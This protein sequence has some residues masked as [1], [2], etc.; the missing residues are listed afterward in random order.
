[1]KAGLLAG[2]VGFIP[3]PYATYSMDDFALSGSN[4]TTWNDSSAGNHDLQNAQSPV[5][6]ATGINGNPTADFQDADRLS[7]AVF[8]PPNPAAGITIVLGIR[9]DVLAVDDIINISRSGNAATDYQSGIC[10]QNRGSGALGVWIGDGAGGASPAVS[11]MHGYTTANSVVTTATN[12]IVTVE[13]R[14][15]GGPTLRV[16]GSS[17]TMTTTISGTLA[18]ADWLANIGGNNTQIVVGGRMNNGNY[19]DGDIIE[20]RIINGVGPDARDAAEVAIAALCGV[21]LP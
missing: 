3:T 11:Q 7:S 18:P 6:D 5:R 2:G 9:L 17:V 20:I 19:F 12:Y 16:N 10:L 1:V 15:S 14:N 4:I 13:M 21:S 8:A